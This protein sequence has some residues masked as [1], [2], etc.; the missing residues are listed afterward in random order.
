M[1][2]HRLDF[3]NLRKE[4]VARLRS[5]GITNE[6]VLKAFKDVPR[7]NFVPL[8]LLYIS[9]EDMPILLG[10]RMIVPHPWITAFMLQA[11]NIKK[12]DNVLELGTN[13]GYQAALISQLAHS[14]ATCEG[15]LD[16]AMTASL[17]L[18]SEYSNTRVYTGGHLLE[19]L[20]TKGPFDVI[21]SNAPINHF[22]NRLIEQLKEGGRM[23][24]PI[25]SGNFEQITIL[26]KTGEGVIRKKLLKLQY[27]PLP[28]TEGVGSEKKIKGSDAPKPQQLP[29]DLKE[30]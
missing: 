1:S 18:R 22:P 12:D 4:M 2:L 30:E 16:M 6:A 25:K 26:Q 11:L 28:D 21:I 3:G 10:D 23:I 17:R 9:Y 27:V 8:E 19:G 14:V 13:S 29:P 15:I 24:F 7:E 20:P 5:R